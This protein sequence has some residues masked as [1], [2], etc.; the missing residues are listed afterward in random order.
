MREFARTVV[1]VGVGVGVSA[2]AVAILQPEHVRGANGYA[3]SLAAIAC[4]AAGF[5]IAVW[6][7]NN[8]D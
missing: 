4:L 8:W 2:I 6:I 7:Y 1:S 5:F 3:Q